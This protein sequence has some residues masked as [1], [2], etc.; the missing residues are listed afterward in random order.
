MSYPVLTCRPFNP[1]RTGPDKALLQKASTM[2]QKCVRGWLIRLMFERLKRKVGQ[3]VRDLL[4]NTLYTGYR[5][6][7]NMGTIIAIET[8]CSMSSSR[9]NPLEFNI[10][11]NIILYCQKTKYNDLKTIIIELSLV[12]LKPYVNYIGS[13]MDGLTCFGDIKDL[14]RSIFWRIRSLNKVTARWYQDG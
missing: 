8:A 13:C 14:C 11:H 3:G 4:T 7:I 2:I 10:L 1:K 12:Y 6:P 5:L 9:P